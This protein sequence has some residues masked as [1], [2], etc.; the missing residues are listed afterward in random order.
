MNTKIEM[1][2]NSHDVHKTTFVR[3]SEDSLRKMAIDKLK[4]LDGDADI[5]I[6]QTA[7]LHNPDN[8]QETRI[9]F[10]KIDGDILEEIVTDD[11]WNVKRVP[12][13]D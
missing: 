10:V 11:P 7:F 5:F 3:R 13:S 6:E 12:I 2:S 9:S 8:W 4:T 1:W